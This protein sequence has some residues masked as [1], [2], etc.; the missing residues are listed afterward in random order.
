MKIAV[1]LGGTSMERDVSVASGAQVVR[2]LREAGHDVVAVES[3]QGVLSP[4]QE[5]ELLA[6][7]IERLPPE[8]LGEAAT[9]LPAIVVNADL[10]DVDLVFVALHGGA[11]ED[12]TVQ[13]LLDLAGMRYTGSGALGAR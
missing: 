4:A 12:G 11:G 10:A 3:T 6:A 8:Q 9:R 7:G 2:A 5:T 13:A 1:L